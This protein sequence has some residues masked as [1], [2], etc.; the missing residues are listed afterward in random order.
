M[1][2]LARVIRSGDTRELFPAVVVTPVVSYERSS[3]DILDTQ[4]RAVSKF[5]S[6]G[7]SAQVGG[8]AK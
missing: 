7:E 3:H 8:E 5:F 4:V 6:I 1:E 2:G